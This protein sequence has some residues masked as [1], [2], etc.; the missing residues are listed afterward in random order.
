MATNFANPQ[1]PPPLRD[2][3]WQAPLV[4]LALAATAGIVLDRRFSIPLPISLACVVAFVF[5][6]G[7]SLRTAAKQHAAVWLWLAFVAAGAAYHQ[8][9]RESIAANDIRLF[10][11]SE[12]RPARLRGVIDS[13]PI[14]APPITSDP[15]RTVATK[16]STRMTVGVR[17][18]EHRGDWHAVSG[19]VQATVAGRR[20]RLH[21]GDEVELTGMLFLPA[22]PANPGEFNYAE[23]LRDQ[24]IGATLSV[25]D[26]ADA[27]DVVRESWPR[28]FSGWLAVLRGRGVKILQEHLPAEQ[29]GVAAALLL[30]DGSAMTRDDWEQYL[31]TGVI[32]VLA[33][34]GQ[35]LVVLAIFLS[36]VG[37]LLSVR[38]RTAALVI[39][40]L[41]LGYALLTGGRSP[42]MR[43][44]W[45]VAAY[46][47]GVLLR[48]PVLPAN[49]LALAWLGVAAFNPTDI[50]NTG[51]QLSFVAVAVLIWGTGRW[52][53][54]EQDPLEKLI[55]ASRSWITVSGLRFIRWL[56]WVYAVNAVVWLAVTPLVAARYHVISPVALLIGPPMV[57]SSS[58][59][60]L[61]GFGLLLTAPVLPPLA[62]L[63]AALT[64][65]SLYLCETLVRWSSAWPGAYSFVPDI[66]AW[67]L[68]VFYAGLL[69]CL[70]VPWLQQR[71][72]R[73]LPVG[74]C[75]LTLGGFL[76][77][78]PPDHRQ[79]RC[80]FLAVGHG[81]CTVI[82]TPGNRVIL[83]DA[84][85]ITG[86]DVT[87]RHIAPF[88][89]SRGY[90]RI[91]DII[92]SHGD[93]D[94][95]NGVPALL[96]RFTVDRVTL[97]P[98]FPD[99][100]TPGIGATLRA[101]DRSGL[102]PRVIHAPA[103]WEVDGIYFEALH[104]PARGPE[105]IEN[106][107]SLVLAVRYEDLTMLL[108]G[109]LEEP[110]LKRVL[111]LPPMNVDVLMAPHHGSRA[112]NTKELAAWAKPNFVVSC[113]GTPK[114][115]V[116]EPNPY[117]ALG[118]R[119]LSTWSQGA[120][121]IRR[122]NRNWIVESFATKNRLGIPR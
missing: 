111:A 60:L 110:G 91:D 81:G 47:G 69:A 42:V 33:I 61:L 109:D 17:Q 102:K 116:R 117:E 108:T 101:L 104:P 99:H 51:C 50:F 48:R 120:V 10:A 118:A 45:V 75:W 19:S 16:P 29:H 14:H 24:R 98:S 55:D 93:L 105:G 56:A 68:G 53:A 36:F 35:H 71:W 40:L 59:A 74:I 88:L 21:I 65:A 90:R 26:A 41:L 89:W 106:V 92:I 62:A 9:Y 86:P 13:E 38:R 70:S 20:N 4:P 39:A 112:S 3:I 64:K 31:R 95:F 63:F 8:W 2:L 96:E 82:E 49:T 84:G 15:L 73:C 78:W 23:F 76:V 1:S 30:G 52:Q 43:A 34:S 25:P 57:L 107:R 72:R 115:V 11:T 119:W 66:P 121:T 97:T 18:L 32:H 103:T 44:A 113:Q 80:T 122:D 83:Y 100:T 85:A 94:H 7:L 5:A 12:G 27:V 6:W 46:A 28:S 79:F 54:R 87:R 37:K 77:F 114:S 58:L 67:W 22:P